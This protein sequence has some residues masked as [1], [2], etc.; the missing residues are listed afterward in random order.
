MADIEIT[1]SQLIELRADNTL[2]LPDEI[3]SAL[4]PGSRIL[5]LR[6]GDT[7]ILKRVDLQRHFERVAAMQDDEPPPTMD[8]MQAIIE[9]VRRQHRESQ[10]K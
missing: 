1:T 5:V 7:V 9:E 10:D 6:Q 2:T 8:E 4:R 3:A